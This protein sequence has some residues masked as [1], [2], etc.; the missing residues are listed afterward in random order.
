MRSELGI[1]QEVEQESA[2]E[3]QSTTGV[4]REGER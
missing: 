4:A 1:K 3:K 2:A